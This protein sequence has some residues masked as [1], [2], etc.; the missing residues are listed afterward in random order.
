MLSFGRIKFELL[1]GR[2]VSYVKFFLSSMEEVPF[3]P[4]PPSSFP[5]IFLRGNILRVIEK[6]MD[7]EGCLKLS[8]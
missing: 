2:K 4:S 8:Y 1:E 3:A 6:G 7:V 5:Q